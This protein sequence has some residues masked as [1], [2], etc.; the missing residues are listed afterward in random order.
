A[1]IDARTFDLEAEARRPWHVAMP[2]PLR[3]GVVEALVA[4]GQADAALA[5][6]S[7]GGEVHSQDACRAAWAGRLAQANPAQ[8]LS[9]VNAIVQAPNVSAQARCRAYAAV[10]AMAIAQ[11]DQT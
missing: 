1:A 2:V 11:K 6:A 7:N 10:A 4:R 5:F 8:A 3:I 9:Q